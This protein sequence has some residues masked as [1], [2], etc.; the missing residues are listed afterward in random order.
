M[1][2]DNRSA[3]SIWYDLINEVLY[4]NPQETRHLL[5]INL[6]WNTS[7]TGTATYLRDISIV[8]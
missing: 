5:V 8:L 6:Q 7:L 2:S 4:V 1:A 3:Y